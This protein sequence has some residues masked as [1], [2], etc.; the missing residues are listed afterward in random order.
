MRM[1][2]KPQRKPE[3]KGR[4]PYL[5]VRSERYQDYFSLKSS[6]N[7][8]LH[9][10]SPTVKQSEIRLSTG[11]ICPQGEEFMVFLRKILCHFLSC[12]FAMGEHCKVRQD[13][14]AHQARQSPH[15]RALQ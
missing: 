2:E 5:S 11:V 1:K 9:V 10:L 12:I 14:L 3:Q 13:R 15:N 7:S 8:V 4:V 6:Q